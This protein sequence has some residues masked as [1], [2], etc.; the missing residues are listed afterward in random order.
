MPEPLAED[1]RGNALLS[2]VRK[3]ECDL[4]VS[5][6]ELPLP[7]ALVLLWWEGRCLLVFDRWKQEWELPGG[8]IEDGETPRQA[9]ARELR[10]ETGQAPAG[11]EFAGEVTFRLQPDSRLERA[12]VFETHI[13]DSGTFEPNDE[14]EKV[15]WWQ[16]DSQ[17]P[18]REGLDTALVRQ[19]RSV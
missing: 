7:L 12:A 4:A 2:F 9:A 13:S 10:E 15:C 17:I 5:T 1:A 16:P 18:E 19:C 3:E 11:L 8:V 14:I 6:S